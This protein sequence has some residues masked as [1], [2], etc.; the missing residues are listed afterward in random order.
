MPGRAD[1]PRRVR[2]PPDAEDTLLT[3]TFRDAEDGGTELRLEHERITREPPSTSQS[4]NA[5]WSQTLA[6]L[7]ALYDK[8]S[9]A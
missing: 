7:Q 3:L 2:V 1:R 6:K 9:D 5:G 4:V 8:E